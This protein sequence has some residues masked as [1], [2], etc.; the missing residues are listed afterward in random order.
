MSFI[1]NQTPRDSSKFEKGLKLI[2]FRHLVVFGLI[3]VRAFLAYSNSFRLPFQ[4]DDRPNIVNNP[5]V[6]IKDSHGI[7]W[8]NWSRKAMWK[9]FEYS[10]IS[11]WLSITIS[12]V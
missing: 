2:R 7:D 8:H 6:K 1:E 11:H 4:F 9:T 3:V 5:D 12:E 10:P